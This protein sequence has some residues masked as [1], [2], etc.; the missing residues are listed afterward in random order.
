MVG[1]E[2][3]NVDNCPR[4]VLLIKIEISL[5]IGFLMEAEGIAALPDHGVESISRLVHSA[6]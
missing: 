6:F 3:K 4:V 2:K 1:T 5:G